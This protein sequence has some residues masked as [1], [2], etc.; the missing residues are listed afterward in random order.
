[1]PGKWTLPTLSHITSST[2]KN[3]VTSNPLL[4]DFDLPP[5][6]A[7]RPEHVEPAIDQILADNRAAIERLLDSQRQNPS[8]SGLVQA[9]DELGARLGQAWSPV[10]HLNAVCNSPELRDA[11]QAD[12]EGRPRLK[13]RH[14]IGGADVAA[15]LDAMRAIRQGAE[16]GATF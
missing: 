1:M 15:E 7:I 9:L 4:Q 2:G 8:W 5:F 3:A 6:S 11:Y 12:G 14:L 10:S 13:N 16:L